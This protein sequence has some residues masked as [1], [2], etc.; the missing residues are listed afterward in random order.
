MFEKMSRGCR[1]PVVVEELT[2]E[3]GEFQQRQER[4]VL[5]GLDHGHGHGREVLQRLKQHRGGVLGQQHHRQPQFHQFRARQLHQLHWRRLRH[6][7]WN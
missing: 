2:T 5:H 3:G 7:H 6:F 1:M 4:Q